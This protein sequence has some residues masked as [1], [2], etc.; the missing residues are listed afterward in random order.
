[1][2][3]VIFLVM[4]CALM[5]FGQSRSLG[6]IHPV[7]KAQNK[8]MDK[9]MSEL[10]LGEIRIRGNVISDQ[11]KELDG[12]SILL[13]IGSAEGP[14]VEKRLIDKDFDLSF[15]KVSSV[16][17]TFSKPGFYSEAKAFAPARE[18]NFF[19]DIELV[20]IGELVKLRELKGFLTFCPKAMSKVLSFDDMPTLWETALIPDNIANRSLMPLRGV[21]LSSDLD[22][23]GNYVLLTEKDSFAPKGVTINAFDKADGFIMFESDEENPQ[24]AFRSMRIAPKIGYE[25]SVLIPP[26]RKTLYFYCRIAGIYGKGYVYPVNR[27]S[28]DSM[29]RIPFGLLLQAEKSNDR[30]VTGIR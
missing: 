13:K 25:Q 22:E 17:L 6:D 5:W 16:H 2:N 23:N 29:I 24:R 27:L 12:V 3:K 20:E 19:S 30:N 4:L 15:K 21:Y 14:V 7:E 11:G 28:S 1:M 26:G 10:R 8:L 9:Y 18:V